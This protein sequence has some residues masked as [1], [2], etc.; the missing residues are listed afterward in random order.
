MTPEQFD[1]LVEMI[2]G[3]FATLMCFV[4]ISIVDPHWLRWVLLAAG[5]LTTARTLRDFF[6]IHL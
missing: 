1:R 6:R 3:M 5:S 4:G 2:F